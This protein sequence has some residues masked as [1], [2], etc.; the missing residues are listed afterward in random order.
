[1]ERGIEGGMKGGV[2]GG[3]EEEIDMQY[4]GKLRKH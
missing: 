1:M 3:M 4:L 2:E